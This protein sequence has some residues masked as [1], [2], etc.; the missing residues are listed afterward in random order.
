M[1]VIAKFERSGATLFQHVFDAQNSGDFADGV[2]HALS[3]VREDRKD[4]DLLADDVTF[5][6]DKFDAQGT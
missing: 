3:K 6:V 5:K 1:R 4:I 2:K